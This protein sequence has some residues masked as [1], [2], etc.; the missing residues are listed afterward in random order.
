MMATRRIRTLLYG[1]QL[2]ENTELD[3]LHTPALQRLYDL[4]QL[5]L[6]DRVFVDASHSRFH[7]I[8]GVLEQVDLILTA[9]SSNLEKK[10]RPALEFRNR[11]GRRESIECIDLANYIRQRRKSVR[12]MGLLHD[13]THAPYGHTLEDEIELLPVKHDN[14]ARQAEAFYRLLGQYIG[15]LSHDGGFLVE[16]ETERRKKS[17]KAENRQHLLAFLDAPTFADLPQT[18]AFI[19]YLADLAAVF[20]RETLVPRKI[21]R[22]PTR[23]EMLRFFR[24]LR[25]AMRALLWLDALHKDK[26]GDLTEPPSEERI[27]E[28][29][30]AYPF[31]QLI[32]RIL[33]PV[34]AEL[35]T[36]EKFHLQRDAFFL[37][38][39]GNTICADLLDYA[40]RDSHFAGLKLDYDVDRIIENFTVVSYHKP[41]NLMEAEKKKLSKLDPVLR[42]AI[43]IS[44]HKLRIDV[45]G[46]LMNLLQVRFYVYQRVL[47][48]PTKCIAGAMLGSALQLIK[49]HELPPH[50]RN[51][52]DSVFLSQVSESVH[53]FRALLRTQSDR[54]DLSVSNV[55]GLRE[56]LDALPNSGTIL[57][58]RALYNARSEERVD[59]ILADFD[60]ALTLL[61]RLEARR[62]HKAIFRLLPSARVPQLNFSAEQIA[63]FFLEPE[64][65]MRAERLIEQLAELPKGT[66]TIHCPTA[67]GPRKI[68]EILMLAE[69]DGDR[70]EE[71]YP[72]R[73]LSSIDR[74]IFEKHEH[75]IKAVEEMY[76]SMWRLMVS[77]APPHYE[78]HVMINK[79]IARALFAVLSNEEYRDIY[80]DRTE[81]DLDM[82]E[83]IPAVPNDVRQT[84]ELLSLEAQGDDEKPM[85]RLEYDDGRRETWPLWALEVS[86]SAL[87]ILKDRITEVA[88]YLEDGKYAANAAE[89]PTLA[90]AIRAQVMSSTTV[91]DVPLDGRKPKKG[92]SKTQSSIP[93][94]EEPESD[95]EE[96]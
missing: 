29:D 75:A 18:D 33:V 67:T 17:L 95:S 62:Y 44:S 88:R 84:R 46:E 58:I 74:D 51:V 77:V 20:V 72:L 55:K 39:I 66:V 56:Q 50:F 2:I 68:A 9:I 79:R 82:D 93:F 43:S 52:G 15:W 14:P 81:D 96:S 8:V 28:P 37:D 83:T 31:E 78:N 69:H 90:D 60:A 25:F 70:G 91:P 26:L 13:L 34:G 22:A 76:R 49:W 6:A 57:A 38:V 19:S 30:G 48:H 65:R 36:S 45:P 53:L 32:D 87:P 35:K 92:T 47:F 61:Q 24:D 63:P 11:S 59:S 1:D 27:V 71:A 5:G 3:L 7:H 40:K 64:N 16:S 89:F 21:D 54:L 10:S 85:V 73:E 94:T 42:T 41:R 80:G 86:T 12:L 4:H 23:R